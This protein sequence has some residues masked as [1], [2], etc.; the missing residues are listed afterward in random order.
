MNPKAKREE[1]LELIGKKKVSQV[2]E[3]I[4]RIEAKDTKET[5][6]WLDDYISGGGN[7]KVLNEAILETLRKFLLI[8]TGVGDKLIKDATPEEYKDLNNIADSLSQNRLSKLIN[9]FSR[10]ITELATATIPQLPLELALVEACDFEVNSENDSSK[11]IE[12]ETK[13]DKKKDPAPK[14]EKENKTSGNGKTNSKEDSSEEKV[15]RKIK[16]AW[17]S[18]LKGVRSKNKSLEMFMKTA[19]PESVEDETLTLK[20]YYQFHK[21][22]VEDDKNR[23]IIEGIIEQEVASPVKIRG[24]MGGKPPE[25][26]KPKEAVQE[27]QTSDDPTQIFGGFD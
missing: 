11:E 21:D 24:V 17:P 22:R 3:I 27:S 10:S 23:M 12:P 8:K 7:V 19:V 25:K 9:L 1:I 14:I 4:K 6:I 20:F 2:L 18:I 16:D 15:L 13:L 26:A 5:I